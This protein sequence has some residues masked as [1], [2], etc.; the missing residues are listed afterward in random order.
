VVV[1]PSSVDTHTELPR[2]VGGREDRV[3]RAA[4]QR[5]FEASGL[6]CID[7]LAEIGVLRGEVV[8]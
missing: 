2:G 4:S 1:V 8:D 3:L 7:E 6:H 5:I